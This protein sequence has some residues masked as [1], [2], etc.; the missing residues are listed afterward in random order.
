MT[1][2]PLAQ[3]KILDF[4]TMMSG[5]MATRLLA[6][7]GADVVKVE[8]PPTGDHNRGRTPVYGGAS[9]YFAQLNA[10]KR[11]VA[12]DLRDEADVEFARALAREADVVVENN[13]PGVMTRLGLDYDDVREG[14]P[15]VVYCSISGYGQR[16][17]ASG[18]AAYAPN[19]H[20]ASGYDL[21]NLRYQNG[22]DTPANTAIFLADVLAAVYAVTAIEAALLA[23]QST[24]RGQYIDL[25]LF[26]VMLNLMVFEMQCAQVDD[27]PARSVYEPIPTTDGFVSVAPVSQIM[28]IALTKALGR[29]ELADDKRFRG[30]PTR[31]L[32]WNELMDIVRQW[33]VSRTT[34]QCVDT[35]S[36]AGVAVAPFRTPEQVMAD[37]YLTERGIVHETTD[38]GGQYYVFNP[39]YTFADGTVHA[40]GGAPALGADRDGVAA[41]WLSGQRR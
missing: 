41:D 29:P 10:G 24:G 2:G 38:A 9:R 33:A 27:K 13:R 19:I 12:L 7:L 11:S 5:P 8:R 36:E 32:H 14:N 35:L 22:S 40:R 18:R 31:E 6:D 4:T 37:P 39:P 26:D 20:A 23:R 34:A 21:A 16:T 25:A 28:F 3:L 17:S 1:Q 15:G 30:G